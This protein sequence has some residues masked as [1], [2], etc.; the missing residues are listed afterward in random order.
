MT[1]M[2]LTT[3]LLRKM[4]AEQEAYRKWLLSLLPM[5]ILEHTYE[6]TVREDILMAL[7]ERE[8][9]A[10]QAMALLDSPNP[11]ADIYRLWQKQDTCGYMSEIRETI[12]NCADEALAKKNR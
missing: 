6:H 7:E 2:E 10:E 4:K 11:L 8:L 9:S 3:I 12:E 1:D 5:E